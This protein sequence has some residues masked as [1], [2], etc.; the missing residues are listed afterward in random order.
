MTIKIEQPII[1]KESKLKYDSRYSFGD[2]SNIAIINALSP[3]SKC[4]NLSTFYHRL[5]EFKNL[6]P[7]TEKKQR[8][9]KSV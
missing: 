8:K 5:S 7:W 3:K 9:E 1:T 6:V 2:C 4:N